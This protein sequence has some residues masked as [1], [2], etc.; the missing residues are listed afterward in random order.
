MHVRLDQ[1]KLT[2]L[3]DERPR[4]GLSKSRIVETS[5]TFNFIQYPK[6][7]IDKK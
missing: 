3:A 6:K 4:R 7:R 5:D 2:I 1:H